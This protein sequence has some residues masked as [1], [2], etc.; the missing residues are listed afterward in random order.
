MDQRGF[1]NQHEWVTAREALAILGVRRETLYAYV[2]RGMV[3][4]ARAPGERTK[5]YAR[6]DLLG[7]KQRHDARSGHG[8]VAAGALRWGEPVLESS[9]TE[10]TADGPRYRGHSAVA[11]AGEGCGFEATAELLWTGKRADDPVRFPRRP[12]LPVV[13]IPR[14]CSPLDAMLAIVPMTALGDPDRFQQSLDAEIPRARA[15]IRVL[16]AAVALP[17]GHRRAQIAASAE[18]VAEGLAVA[19]GVRPTARVVEAID[20]ALV[21][22][23]DHELNASTFAARVAA[24]AGAD[25]YASVIAGLGAL[26]GPRHGGAC[27]RVEAL[28]D[29]V[30]APRDARAVLRARLRRGD[31]LPGFG[32]RLYPRGDARA[33]LLLAA[34]HDLGKKTA[35]FRIVDAIRAANESFEGEPPTLDLGLVAIAA[36]F[37][38]PRGAPLAMFALG[39][40][41]GWVAHIFEQRAQGFMMRPRARF[42]SAPG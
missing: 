13:S 9:I 16:G 40:S 42:V 35:R 2:S 22:S 5:R 32:H 18:T 37:D 19:F 23:A 7:L 33:E 4:S 29:E 20:R 38:L 12:K 28:V 11:L 25:L 24:S 34:A 14:A 36:A 17:F 39:R 31:S 27:D 15:L 41:A 1:D 30:A 3:R 10:I 8:P 26:S 6:S 21:I